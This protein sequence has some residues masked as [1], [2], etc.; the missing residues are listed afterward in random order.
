M[1]IHRRAAKRDDVEAAVVERLQHHG[2]TVTRLSGTGVPDLLVVT[3]RGLLR[4]AEVKG[5]K[6]KLTYAQECY[7]REWRG[8]PI[9]ILT[10]PEDATAWIRSLKKA[11]DREVHAFNRHDHAV[12]ELEDS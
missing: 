1:S 6:A 10:S 2:C 3:R 11:E 12:S 7:H 8:P 5:P 4:V 9:A